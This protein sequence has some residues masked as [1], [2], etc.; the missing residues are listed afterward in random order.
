[1]SMS[2]PIADM[3]T[4]IRNAQL[5]KK[6]KVQIPYSRIKKSIAK[7][8]NDEGYIDSY[9][10][11]NKNNKNMIEISLKYHAGKSVIESIKRV[12]KPGLRLYSSCKNLP[13]VMN[14][15]GITI[16]STSNGVMTE[17]NAK[18]AGIGGELICTVS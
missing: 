17:K 6:Q 12:S 2:D 10:I 9:F 1:M 4:R 11:V 15:L 7:V 13:T 14:G 3:L 18:I 8:L 16:V 5:V